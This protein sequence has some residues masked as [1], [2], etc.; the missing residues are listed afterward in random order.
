M[1][2]SEGPEWLD[3]NVIVTGSAD[4]SLQVNDQCS[5]QLFCCCYC[6]ILSLLL[7][8]LLLL[9]V[10]VVLVLLMLLV[11]LL[12]LVV[13]VVLPP[14]LLVLVLFRLPWLLLMHS[15]QSQVE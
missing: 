8:L 12:L 6:S 3:T 5:L 2:V 9:L 11:L 10:V 7:L 14:P 1:A 4:G 15:P 13:V